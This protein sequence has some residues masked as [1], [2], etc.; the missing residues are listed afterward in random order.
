[1]VTKTEQYLMDL[2]A[3]MG[4]GSVSV[5]FIESEEY[6]NGASV[7]EV[8]Y[9]NEFGKPGQPPRPFFRNMV[10]K[11][12]PDWADT[13]AR[14]AKSA[15]YNG[16]VILERMGEDIAA[17]LQESMINLTEPALSPTT[18][19]LRKKFWSNPEK[20]TRSDVNEARKAVAAGETGAT[21]TQAKPLIWTH[22]MLDS[23]TY[24][25]EE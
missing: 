1:M 7:P 20:I 22:H 14:T 2:A 12:K 24:E 6:P 17:A 8:A 15:N 19:M 9:M 11:E 16:K 13:M 4:N 10:E 21:G 3:K 25:V 18:L 5:G 23:I